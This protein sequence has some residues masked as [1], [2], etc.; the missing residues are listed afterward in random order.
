[1]TLVVVAQAYL[2]LV[3]VGVGSVVVEVRRPERTVGGGSVTV[4]EAVWRRVSVVVIAGA[5]T[6]ATTETGVL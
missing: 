2:D 5:V 1:M 6:V 3:F 4:A